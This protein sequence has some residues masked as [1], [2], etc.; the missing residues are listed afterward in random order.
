MGIYSQST[1]LIFVLLFVWA[2]VAWAIVASVYRMEESNTWN[3]FHG[4]TPYVASIVGVSVSAGVYTIQKP[5]SFLSEI[6]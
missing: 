4:Y 3:K 5:N 1:R 2:L 6:P